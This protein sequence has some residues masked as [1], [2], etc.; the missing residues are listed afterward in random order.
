MRSGQRGKRTSVV[1][2]TNVSPHG[3]WLLLGDRELFLSFDKFP[4]FR[5][6]PIAKL[7][8]VELP[9]PDHLYWPDLDV[10]LA[11]ESIEHPERFPL[12]SK[13]RSNARLQRT[14]GRGRR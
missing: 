10:D 14:P 12:V 1:E 3:F 4:W 6:A 11:V 7:V 9:S 5:D 8:R 13:T 2:V